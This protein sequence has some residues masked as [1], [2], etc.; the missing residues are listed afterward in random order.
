MPGFVSALG[1]IKLLPRGGSGLVRSGPD[2]EAFRCLGGDPLTER[3]SSKG[4]LPLGSFDGPRIPGRT[5]GSEGLRNGDSRTSLG[6]GKVCDLFSDCSG[7]RSEM[8]VTAGGPKPP[9]PF[10]PG[11]LGGEAPDLKPP[12]LLVED[13]ECPGPAIAG[14]CM[15]APISAVREDIVASLKLPAVGCLWCPGRSPRL[16]RTSNGPGA[17]VFILCRSPPLLGVL[18]LTGA[19]IGSGSA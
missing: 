4:I 2:T 10:V 17:I 5:V 11:T 14:R 13:L 7:S 16:L 6:K 15:F 1:L 3:C 18:G 19:Y 12:E 9:S 8:S